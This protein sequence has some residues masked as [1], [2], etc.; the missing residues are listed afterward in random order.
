LL[1]AH[2]ELVKLPSPEAPLFPVVLLVP[3]VELVKLRR[4]F[5]D[6]RRLRGELL[7]ERVPQEIRVLF[8]DLDLGALGFFLLGFRLGSRNCGGGL[9]LGTRELNARA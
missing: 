6:K 4:V 8:D 1:R 2:H 7:D 5:A 3:A 9:R